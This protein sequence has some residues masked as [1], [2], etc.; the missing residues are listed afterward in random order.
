MFCLFVIRARLSVFSCLFTDVQ[1]SSNIVF[2]NGNL[3]PWRRGGVSRTV[4]CPLWVLFPS[5]RLPRSL[6]PGYR[7]GD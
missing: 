6:V 3:D 7:L 4:L 5:P 1:H 2:S